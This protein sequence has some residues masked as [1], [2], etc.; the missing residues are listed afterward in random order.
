MERARICS[1]SCWLTAP[2]AAARLRRD[3][4]VAILEIMSGFI[5]VCSTH[6][7]YFGN[8][9]DDWFFF[10]RTLNLDFKSTD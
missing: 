8:I 10:S 9:F 6:V 3:D 4:D 5:F 7:R 1:A 2:R